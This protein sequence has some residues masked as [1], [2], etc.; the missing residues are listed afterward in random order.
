MSELRESTE[1]DAAYAEQ[2]TRLQSTKM[3]S[4][5]RSEH[6]R[7]LAL[8]VQNSVAQVRGAHPQTFVAR[9]FFRQIF[10]NNL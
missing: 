7:T 9:H 4:M 2:Q 10:S 3:P 1:H 5:R 8:Q 6:G